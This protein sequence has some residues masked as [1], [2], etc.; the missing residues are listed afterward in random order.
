MRPKK[1]LGQHFLTSTGAIDDILDA[2]DITEEDLVLE[3]GPGKGVLTEKLVEYAEKVMAIEKDSELIP[4]LKEKFKKEIKNKKL[5]IAE[6]DI[7]EFDPREIKKGEYKLVANLPYYITG[8]FIRKF[9]ETEFQPE[10]MVL[11]LQKEVAERIARSEKESILSISVKAYGTPRYVK[12]VKAGSFYP[13]PNVDSAILAI[14]DISKEFFT[15]FSEE[16]FFKLLHAGFQSKRKKLSSNLS[17]VAPKSKVL[18]A[19]KSLKLDENV[20]AEDVDLENWRRLAVA[21]V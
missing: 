8:L 1:S 16:H 17:L 7:L 6:Q 15:G 20:R 13:V 11:M 4:L 9:L 3:V 5:E 14:T 18:E 10:R 21:L 2:A 12:T 19:F